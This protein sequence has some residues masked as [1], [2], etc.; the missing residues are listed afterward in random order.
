MLNSLTQI[1]QIHHLC[2]IF[3][4]QYN[5]NDKYIF[6]TLGYVCVLVVSLVTL[7]FIRFTKET[8][9][10]NNKLQMLNIFWA[11]YDMYVDDVYS[12]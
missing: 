5:N 8:T 4:L 3:F 1:F 6:A 11:S 2:Q 9:Y 7:D 12:A 10:V